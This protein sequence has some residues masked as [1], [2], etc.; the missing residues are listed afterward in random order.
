MFYGEY[1]HSLD[2][3]GRIT[4]PV[5]YREE[6]GQ[7]FIATKGLDECITLYP[8]DEWEKYEQK[9]RTLPTV[10]PNAR[11]YTR[12]LYSS[13]AE[14][15]MDRQGRVLLPVKLRSYAGIEKDLVLIGIGP[16]VEIWAKERWAAYDAAQEKDFVEIA[17]TLE[18][19]DI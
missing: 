6:L 14:L 15:E 19:H 11:G 7:E 8:R 16:R 13:V 9:L 17:S 18:D 1:Q 2:N 5:K 10:R 4:I 12:T 3:K